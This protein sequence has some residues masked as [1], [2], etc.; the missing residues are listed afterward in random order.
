[1]DKRKQD[2]GTYLYLSRM[3]IEKKI[4]QKNGIIED[5]K[6]KEETQPINCPQCKTETL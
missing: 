1:M 3:D 2:A 6:K 5:D 4:L